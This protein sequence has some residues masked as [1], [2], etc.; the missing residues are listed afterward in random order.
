MLITCPKCHRHIRTDAPCPFCGRSLLRGS[1]PM[2]IVGGLAAVGAAV[3]L[4]ACYGPPPTDGSDFDD[5]DA[6]AKQE[7]V[8]ENSDG[9]PAN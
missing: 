6:D 7:Q 5:E 4:A 8:D 3:L 9:A 1:A 2:A